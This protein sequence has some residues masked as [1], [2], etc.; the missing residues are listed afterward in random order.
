MAPHAEGAR[1]SPCGPQGEARG[2][3]LVVGLSSSHAELDSQLDE[4]LNKV[5]LLLGRSLIPESRLNA[6]SGL[7]LLLSSGG[8][9]GGT[10]AGVGCSAACAGWSL[11]A[12]DFSR[13]C[14]TRI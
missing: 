5:G 4:A 10:A 3:V 6:L 9:A 14:L 1:T 12:L 2:F 11:E 7:A 13:Q 8:I